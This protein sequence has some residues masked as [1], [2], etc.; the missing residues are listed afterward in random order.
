M[1]AANNRPM[2]NVERVARAF[3][4]NSSPTP[5][6]KPGYLGDLDSLRTAI[7][8]ADH[9]SVNDPKSECRQSMKLLAGLASYHGP[10]GDA[11]REELCHLYLNPP[12]RMSSEVRAQL[13]NSAL[14]VCVACEPGSQKELAATVLVMA[15]AAPE[16]PAG[17]NGEGFRAMVRQALGH[18][19]GPEFPAAAANTALQAAGG[20]LKNLNWGEPASLATPEA[21]KSSFERMLSDVATQGKTVTVWVADAKGQCVPVVA[22]PTP[23][24]GIRFHVVSQDEAGN[25]VS[26]KLEE[27]TPGEDCVILH[28]VDDTHIA[29]K[30]LDANFHDERGAGAVLREHADGWPDMPVKEQ[31]AHRLVSQAEV[32]QV[33][34]DSRRKGESPAAAANN[35]AAL[36]AA[37][38]RSTSIEDN[39]NTQGLTVQSGRIHS[40][41]DGMQEAIGLHM[42]AADL[43]QNPSV[44]M[45]ADIAAT[46]ASAQF[47]ND[48]RPAV[49]NFWNPALSFA[50]TFNSGRAPLLFGKG[51]ENALASASKSLKEFGSGEQVINLTVNYQQ[52]LLQRCHDAATS[53]DPAGLKK[54]LDEV[55]DVQAKLFANTNAAIAELEKLASPDFVLSTPELTAKA[56][57]EAKSL[58]AA[59]KQYRECLAG[60]NSVEGNVY[61]DLV[62]FAKQAT[63]H[64]PSLE[65]AQAMFKGIGSKPRT[66]PTP[67]SAL[68]RLPP[69]IVVKLPADADVPIVP[70]DQAPVL[71]P[72]AAALPIGAP[73]VRTQAT[74]EELQALAGAAGFFKDDIGQPQSAWYGLADIMQL[75]MIS[76]GAEGA[77]R[78]T[79]FMERRSATNDFKRQLNEMPESQK[80]LTT[81]VTTTAAVPPTLTKS[82]LWG[83]LDAVRHSERARRAEELQ[84]LSAEELENKKQ[85]TAASIL[86]QK[87]LPAGALPAQLV[88]RMKLL[89]LE[90]VKRAALVTSSDPQDANHKHFT[91]LLREAETYLQQVGERVEAGI[92]EL[93][94][95][96]ASNDSAV[97]KSMK[98]DAVAMR[99]ALSGFLGEFRNPAGI[100][101]QTVDFLRVALASPENLTLAADAVVV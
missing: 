57:A 66:V 101:Q 55:V 25:D 38:K 56:K 46:S 3:A 64:G 18:Q 7:E 5:L 44:W 19:L 69:D 53:N 59:L 50:R 10:M 91:T 68:Q 29:L 9:L 11:A 77:V 63:T 1:H 27:L 83:H 13:L 75:H 23:S 67:A 21:A 22:Q 99:D 71:Q 42:K 49:K 41:F 37:A 70:R 74:R 88:V 26:K 8:G 54:A 43:S 14:E 86:E 33:V 87:G 89:N 17:Q 30:H 94:S 31:D 60:E 40:A 36:P 15:E 35:D 28:K 100:T 95:V 78:K 58:I 4:H 90:I 80:R 20:Q 32:A 2:G 34:A 24:G 96:L 48:L 79:G 39:F 65:A 92:K 85:V 84:A 47:S 52:K 98:A 73:L 62:A 93:E 82:R 45:R 81:A 97:T 72:A 6:K 76:I 12:E 61:S 51:D 16:S